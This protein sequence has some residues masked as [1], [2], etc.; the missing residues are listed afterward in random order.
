MNYAEKYLNKKVT[1]KIDRPM[2]S[3][4]PKWGSIYPINYGFIPDTKAP[5]GEEIDAYILGIFEPKKEFTGKCIAVVKRVDDDDDK[6]VVVPKDKNYSDEQIESLIEFQ[7]KYFDSFIKRKHGITVHFL[8]SSGNFKELKK[9][10]KENIFNIFKNVKDKISLKSVDVLVKKGKNIK[11][12]KDLNGIGASCDNDSLIQLRIDMKHPAIKESFKK[13][14]KKTLL[15][16]LHHV[17]RLKAGERIS[18]GIFLEALVSEGLADNFVFEETKEKPKWV[19]VLNKSQ[20]ARLLKIVKAHAD[21]KLGW[22]KYKK[23]FL[24]GSKKKDIP[25]WAGYTLG[26]EIVKKFLNKNPKET[27]ASLVRQKPERIFS[28]GIKDFYK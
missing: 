8:R 18:E 11:E 23:W 7:E 19:N 21:Q 22:E 1:V 20:Q 17:T 13:V 28:E 9:E 15:H 24:K 2:G 14:L 26:F 5:D 6:L 25:K 10:I 27:A 4:H 3:K 16:E 12:L